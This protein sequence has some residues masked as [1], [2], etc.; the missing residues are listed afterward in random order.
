[1]KRLFKNLSLRNKIAIFTSLVLGVSLFILTC[2][3]IK[4]EE[5][6]SRRELE[7]QARILLRTLPYSIRDELY[8]VTLDE[9]KDVA[10]HIADSDHL[11]RFVIYDREGI[12]LADSDHPDIMPSN[13]PDPFG[14]QL[15]SMS[16]T[17]DEQIYWNDKHLMAGQAVFLE[18]ECIGAVSV[19]LSTATLEKHRQAIINQ[20]ISLSFVILTIGIA[21]SFMLAK[22]I[23]NPLRE[24][25][26]ISHEM[27]SGKTDMRAK[28][29][30]HDEIGELALAFNDMA[31]SIQT[32]ERDLRKLT[33]SLEQKVNKRTKE[34]RQRNDELVKIATTDPLTQIN[35]RRRFFNL[36]AQ[37]YE[38]A[39]R[40]KHDF[41]LIIIDADYF[42]DVNDTY[43]HQIGDQVLKNLA[44]FLKENIRKID[45]VA[46][47]GGEEFIILMPE[48]SGNEAAQVAERLHAMI[49]ETPMAKDDYKIF[50]TVCFGVAYW[51]NEENINLDNLLYRADKA[52]YKAKRDGRNHITVWDENMKR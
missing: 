3:T 43:G 48:I 34:L 14:A 44:T 37:E 30:T 33:T 7:Q 32:R 21:L 35:N 40:Y 23:S 25:M 39:Q 6:Y 20:S 13:I 41:S 4:L 49:A 22:Q 19:T 1:M 10:S 42:K 46:R 17:D 36:A 31:E 2:I 5:S 45:I 15:V 52:L 24:L 8:F 27:A 9:L 50:I 29:A 28:V 38:R 11:T 18:N 51:T 12:A 26:H 47:Y 16:K